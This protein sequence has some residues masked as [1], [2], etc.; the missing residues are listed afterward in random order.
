MALRKASAYSKKKVT[1]YTRQSR[2]R[3]KSYIKTV[4][5]SK[6]VKYEMGDTQGFRQGKYPIVLHLISNED[7][8]IRHNAFEAVRQYVHKALTKQLSG[9]YFFGIKAHPHQILREN[10]MLTGAGADRMQSGMKHS[11]G[12]PV[13]RAAV[14]KKGKTLLVVAVANEKAARVAKDV[15]ARVK[16]KF[17]CKTKIAMEK[18]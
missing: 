2:Q 7:V 3:S 16:A 14:V 17:P 13:G 10:K 18:L 1:P 5:A 15:L 4:P 8:Q 9:M 12:K 6:I 11:F